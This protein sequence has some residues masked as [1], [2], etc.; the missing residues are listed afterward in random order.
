MVTEAPKDLLQSETLQCKLMQCVVSQFDTSRD[1]SWYGLMDCTSFF[2]SII[3]LVPRDKCNLDKA[4]YE[5]ALHIT[6][7]KPFKIG[8]YSPE[9]KKEVMW[10]N[11]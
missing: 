11:I 4:T 2:F 1:L 5:L 6:I 7:L 10:M 3:P 8:L 9:Q